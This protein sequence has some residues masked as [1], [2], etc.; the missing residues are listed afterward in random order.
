MTTKNY[1]PGTSGYLDPEG[2]SWETTVYQA[3]KPV[4]DKELNFAQDVEQAA[5]RTIGRKTYPSGWLSDNFLN[6]SVS[7]LVDTS[8]PTA[9][10]LKTPLLWAAVN[11]WVLQVTNTNS[12]TGTNR[13]SLGA[14]P[15]GV[16]AKR[17]DFVILEVWRR[18]IPAAPTTTGKSPG[19]LIWRDGNVKIASADDLTLN[20][21]DDIKDGAVGAE[22]TKRVQIQYR[23]RVVNGVDLFTY[24]FGLDDPSLVAR[25]VP[26][27][28]AAPDGTAT[29][30]TYT[31][32]SS[33][34]D[35]GLW[36]AGN[37]DPANTL[38]TVDGY[39]YAIP[40]CAVFRRNTSAFSR[41]TNHNGGVAS[42]GPSDRPDGL[43]YD[44]VAATD[45][46]DMRRG[47]SPSGWDLTEIAQKNLNFL[48][49]NMIQ[50]EIGTTLNGGGV[51]GHTVMWADEIGIS[52]AN[53]GD[54]TITGDTPGAD[55]IGEF[56]AARRTFS[57]K[58][59]YETVVLRYTPSMGSGG[60]PTWNNGDV[61][62][63]TPSALPIWPYTAFNWAASAP[64]GVSIIGIR[65]VVQI[66]ESTGQ[67]SKDLTSVSGAWYAS[68]L[69]GV[70]QGTVSFTVGTIDP[71]A[72]LY[73]TIV[74][75][76]PP[77]V[78]LT[79]TP[80][81][82][83]ADN[84]TVP[85]VQGVFVNNPGQLPSSSPIYYS[86]LSTPTFKK[87]QRE[88]TLTYRTVSHVLNY[89]TT[90]AS[91]T[92][93]DT[94]YLPERALTGTISMTISGS[95]YAGPI[96]LAS[97]G[98]SF[99]ITPTS[100][101]A[102]NAVVVTYQSVRPLPKN[103]EQLTV[104]YETRMPQTIR[105]GVLGTSL[106][107]TPRVAPNTMYVL[108]SGSGSDGEAYP[109]PT[110]YV[111]VGGVYPGSGGSFDGDHEM[112]GDLR[113][114]TPSVFVDTGFMQLMTHLPVVPSPE[115][116]TFTRSSM[117][118]DVEGRSFFPTISGNYKPF[119]LA[120]VLS[121]P[122]KHKNV[123]PILCELTADGPVGQKGQLVLVLL[124]RWA[125]FDDSNSIL[126]DPSAADNTTTASVYRLK[127]N[128]L[129]NRRS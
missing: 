68:G 73:I 101:G 104:Y 84:A 115:A 39:M 8:S 12:N 83:Y 49:D 74:V 90:T 123:L 11:G 64:A 113:V 35:P 65:K 116:F 44:M 98:Y 33:S 109:F 110:Q 91:P 69:G 114:S 60:G 14:S 87:A 2:R 40:L 28:A 122:K 18:L 117:N 13:I 38:G 94:I 121:D 111:Q 79:K 126:F 48:F 105:S 53:G 89:W 26:A 19:G 88:V 42:P 93:T 7:D 3:S 51:N 27:S 16:G 62:S 81:N 75:A 70:P 96:T 106:Q 63:I 1:G 21:A 95:P 129:S 119:A 30:Y 120:E 46:Y 102:G 124:S 58:V 25:S 52:N 128:L 76:Y 50:T 125:V 32:Q 92:P 82:T 5:L 45:V 61:V 67:K 10:I 66:G 72:P 112:D 22:T 36:R 56:D 23:L 17:T 37:G 34:G 55:F 9:N 4:L 85:S 41:T 6:S 54:G 47:T 71:G 15:T 99:G 43:F 118:V 86:S 77:G 29:I 31:N 59:I 103:G 100:I 57:D 97:D 20:Y 108:T 107:I 24:T 80:T 127:G 78:G